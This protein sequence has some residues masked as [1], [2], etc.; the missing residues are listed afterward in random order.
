MDWIIGDGGMV[1]LFFCDFLDM[2]VIDVLVEDVEK[3]IG[4][5]DI[6]I[7]NVGWLIWW[8]LVELLECWYDVE[9][10]MVFNYYVLLWFICGFVFG[11]FECGDGY[12]INVVIWGVLLEVLLLFLVYNVL[13]VVLLV[14]SWII[15]IEWGS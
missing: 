2:E 4:G 14:V 13:K 3:C 6:L 15:E 11:M 5:I 7:N 12:I 9:C 8:L 10:I 1:M